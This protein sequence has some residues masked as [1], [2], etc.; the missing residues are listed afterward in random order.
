[1][2]T[3]TKSIAQS[4]VSN[5]SSDA[6]TKRKRYSARFKLAAVKSISATN[7]CHSVARRLGLP[8]QTLHNWY[9]AYRE[10]NVVFSDAIRFTSEERSWM[11][12]MVEKRLREL[13]ARAASPKK[14]W[15]IALLDRL[16]AKINP[17]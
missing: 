17:S 14:Q 1:M 12:S 16:R 10:E 2:S 4:G 3:A 8:H 13:N 7:S 9:K 6:P 5:A 11:H 15:E